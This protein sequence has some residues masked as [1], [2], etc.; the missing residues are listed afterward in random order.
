MCEPRLQ[1]KY[2]ATFKHELII[3]NPALEGLLI[4][5]SDF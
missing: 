3:L 5:R 2:N 4:L 1:T